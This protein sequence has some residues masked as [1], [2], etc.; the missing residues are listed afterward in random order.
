MKIAV[1]ILLGGL[2]NRFQET[3][4]QPKPFIPVYGKSQLFWAAKGAWMSYRPELIIFAVR[5]QLLGQLQDEVKLFTFV[6]DYEIIDIG[7]E[8]KGPADTAFRA[9]CKSQKIDPGTRLVIVDNDCFNLNLASTIDSS[10][11]FVTIVEST[12]PQHCYVDFDSEQ[13][14][15][16]FHEKSLYGK[17]AI[18]GN[19]G[20]SN[21]VQFKSAYN[22]LVENA[23]SDGEIFISKVMQELVDK[24]E[25]RVFPVAEY[26]SLGTPAEI[27]NMNRGI[28]KYK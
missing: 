7:L 14:A 18:S 13:N 11:P 26:F 16:N 9:L 19:Y 1:L 4:L 6:D 15:R 8:T 25:I 28:L 17:Y 20:F 5:T 3:F 22:Q 2:G 10:F 23:D 24:V 27:E 12:N 21:L